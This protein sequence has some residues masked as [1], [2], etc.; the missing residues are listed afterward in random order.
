M[1]LNV[2]RNHKAASY[3]GFSLWTFSTMPLLQHWLSPV[4]SDSAAWTELRLPMGSDDSQ[5]S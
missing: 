3:G 4:S 2:R 1:V 5:S